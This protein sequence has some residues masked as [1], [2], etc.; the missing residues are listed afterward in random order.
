M[1]ENVITPADQIDAV[2]A[3]QFAILETPSAGYRSTEAMEGV[4]EY[5]RRAQAV[6]GFRPHRIEVPTSAR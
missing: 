3:V 5:L 2:K 6:Y 1:I 4:R